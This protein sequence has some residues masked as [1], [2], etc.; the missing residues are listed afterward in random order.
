MCERRVASLFGAVAQGEWWRA[1][2]TAE[3]PARAGA[4]ARS[5]LSLLAPERCAPG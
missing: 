4:I 3:Q 1:E 2:S 5:V